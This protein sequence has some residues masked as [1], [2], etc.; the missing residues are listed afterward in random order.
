MLTPRLSHDLEAGAGVESNNN[1]S[2][3]LGVL[4]IIVFP[5]VAGMIC[6]GKEI[7]LLIA[8]KE[9]IEAYRA[10]AILSIALIFSTYACV[11]VSVI[12]LA[13]RRD[14]EIL[15]ASCVSAIINIALNLLLIPRFSYNAAAFTTFVSECLMLAMGIYYTRGTIRLKMGKYLSIA[16]LGV[17]EV[18]LTCLIVKTWITNSLISLLVSIVICGCVYGLT[19]ILLFVQADWKR[20][21]K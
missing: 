21:K 15:I 4:T 12:M 14:K 9:Y 18:C 8:G 11:F 3:V 2:A 6:M 20:V 19:L 1:I 7:I 17:V 16:G 5:V 10:L 13:Q